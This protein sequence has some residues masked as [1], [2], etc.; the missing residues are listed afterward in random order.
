MYFIVDIT[1]SNIDITK[2]ILRCEAHV[3]SSDILETQQRQPLNYSH[4]LYLFIYSL[5]Y[6][7]AYRKLANIYL[8]LKI[9]DNKEEVMGFQ[10]V[11]KLFTCHI[12]VKQN[13]TQ[14]LTGT[15]CLGISRTG[16]IKKKSNQTLLRHCAVTSN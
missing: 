8:C 16:C 14:R 2:L 3:H 7:G 5:I 13:T 1:I 12:P 11:I 15:F 6:W 10:N 4:S 9:S